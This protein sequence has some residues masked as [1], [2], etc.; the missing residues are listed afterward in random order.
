VVAGFPTHGE[1]ARLLGESSWTG[2]A[3]LVLL[4][5]GEPDGYARNW[6]APGF[7]P[8]RHI[9]YAVQWF[10]LALTLAVIYVV[11][12]LRRVDDGRRDTQVS[13]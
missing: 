6:S 12:N 9:A 4:D 7:P 2:A 10:A 8:M 1:I 5:P 3:D 11:T 13:A